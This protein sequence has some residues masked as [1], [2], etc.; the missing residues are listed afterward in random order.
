VI[1]HQ[2]SRLHVG[3]PDC[4]P[5]ETESPLLE[6]FAQRLGFRGRSW[7]L[8]RSFPASEYGRPSDKPPA[9]G[10]K[11]AE[12]LLDL[13]NRASIPHRGL[14][15]HSVANDLRISQKGPNFSLGIA[16]DLLG[17]EPVERPPVT[18]PLLQH[19]R[20]VQPGLRA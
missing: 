11:A 4:W 7:N 16:R 12:L 10:V 19:K 5:D 9:V 1:V 18:F 15:F 13:E 14:D 2:S 6:I 8:A 20:P 17:I 3:I